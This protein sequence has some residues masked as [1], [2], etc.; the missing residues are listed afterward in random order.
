MACHKWPEQLFPAE[1]GVILICCGRPE[2][3]GPAMT[4]PGGNRIREAHGDAEFR[5]LLKVT[6]ANAHKPPSRRV[7]GTLCRIENGRAQIC[8][9]LGRG[10]GAVM[11]GGA[12][13]P[14]S[15]AL[16]GAGRGD[17]GGMDPESSAVR[18]FATSFGGHRWLCGQGRAL[19][20][21][22]YRDLGMARRPVIRRD[23]PRCSQATTT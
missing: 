23:G 15:E 2:R 5:F 10:W 11:I 7:L 17:G 8:G 20:W 19:P 18:E 21:Q 12:G 9:G 4:T 6:C 22:T 16:K 1:A 3:L 14:L 13:Q